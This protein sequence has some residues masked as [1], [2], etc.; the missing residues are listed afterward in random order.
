MFYRDVNLR[1]KFLRL[2]D[3]VENFVMIQG[4]S[5]LIVTM[6]MFIYTLL[7]TLILESS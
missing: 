1:R 5:V 7:F 2:L 3:S 4:K 6:S